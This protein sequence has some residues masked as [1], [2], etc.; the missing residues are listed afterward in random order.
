MSDKLCGTTQKL[1]CWNSKIIIYNNLCEANTN[2]YAYEVWQRGKR[3]LE[4][5]KNELRAPSNFTLAKMKWERERVR[6][7]SFC[8][9]FW[10]QAAILEKLTEKL[11]FQHWIE[12]CQRKCYTPT[13]CFP[14]LLLLRLN[15]CAILNE[16]PENSAVE[17]MKIALL[18]CNENSFF[19]IFQHFHIFL[20]HSNKIQF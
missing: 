13:S 1:K 4:S 7:Y 15:T 17:T 12:F 16:I 14:L 11:K 9:Q 6:I 19:K 3:K 2:T 5:L 20:F 8:H 10:V 18:M